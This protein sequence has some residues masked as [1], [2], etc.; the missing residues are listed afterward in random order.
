METKAGNRSVSKGILKAAI[1]DGMLEVYKSNQ[2]VEP[3][4]EVDTILGKMRFKTRPTSP[5][6]VTIIYLNGHRLYK[7]LVDCRQSRDRIEFAQH[8]E[9]KLSRESFD[10]QCDKVLAYPVTK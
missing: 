1:R 10:R 5:D 6:E 2:P 8:I 7:I 3:E 4:L 9:E